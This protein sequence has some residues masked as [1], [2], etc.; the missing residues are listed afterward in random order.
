MTTDSLPSLEDPSMPLWLL[1]VNPVSGGKRKSDITEKSI[2]FLRRYNIRT[3]TFF[4][5]GFQDSGHIRQLLKNN[6][7]DR[8]VAIGGD[9]TCNLVAQCLRQTSIPMGII[10]AG[11]AN[12]LALDLGIPRDTDQALDLLV[13]GQDQPLDLLV[14]NDKF[15]SLHLSDAGLNANLIWRF[16]QSGQ[17]GGW[18]YFKEMLRSLVRINSFSVRLYC[19]GKHYKS[20]AVMLAFAN[21]SRYGSGAVLNPGGRPDDGKFEVCLIRSL[22]WYRIPVL[23]WHLFR[24]DVNVTPELRTWSTEHAYIRLKRKVLLQADG[25]ILGHHKYIEVKMEKQALKCRR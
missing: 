11:S 14:L 6:P 7:P 15:Y 24:G 2:H 18:S 5:T 17:R 4:L 12:G 3:H 23:A 10:P 20:R 22:K 1:V 13:N 19:N 8:V 9:G 21:G 25:E 16:E